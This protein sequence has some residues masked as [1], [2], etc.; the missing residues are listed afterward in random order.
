MLHCPPGWTLAIF[1]T[2][3]TSPATTIPARWYRDPTFLE[4]KLSSVFGGTW[5]FAGHPVRWR[6][7]AASW[8]T[9]I[10]GEPVL[11]TRDPSGVLG[12]HLQLLPASRRF[13][14][15]GA[16]RGLADWKPARRSRGPSLADVL[17][18]FRKR[19]RRWAALLSGCVFLSAAI[20]KSSA[21]GKFARKLPREVSFARR[22]SQPV[23]RT[24][25]C[26][27]P[28]GDV[29]LLLADRADP[30]RLLP[31]GPDRTLTI[32]EWFVYEGGAG[33]RSFWALLSHG[34]IERKRR[35]ASSTVVER[36]A[37]TVR[38]LRAS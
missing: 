4:A 1:T 16:G 34:A 22:A 15:V 36:V 5:Q 20:M 30:G 9:E 29:P 11:V 17:G 33:H 13:A 35:C 19:S 28:G 23:S 2:P 31:L 25:L 32:F 12:G 6:S 3:R 7:L 27:I 26:A 10:A 18:S 38:S 37:L 21:T 24:E 14:G 8:A